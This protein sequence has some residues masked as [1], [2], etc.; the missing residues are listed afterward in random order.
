MLKRIFLCLLFFSFLIPHQPVSAQDS[1]EYPVYVVQDGDTLSLISMRFGLSVDDLKEVNGIT[2]P[3]KLSAGMELKIPSLQGVSGKLITITVPLGEDLQSLS[4]KYNTSKDLLIR[5]NRITSPQ[6]VYA[7]TNL[8]I[9]QGSDEIALQPFDSLKPQESWL[10]YS[11]KNKENYWSLMF[12]NKKNRSWDFLTSD[13]IYRSSTSEQKDSNVISSL[14]NGISI[15]PL[16]LVQGTT[17]KIRIKTTKPAEINA[18]L[19]E[20]TLH[21]YLDGENEYVALQGINAVQ[22]VGLIP[23]V[24]NIKSSQTNGSGFE[25]MV[26]VTAGNYASDPPLEVDPATLD[27]NTIAQEDN[28]IINVLQDS[29]PTRY[30]K[31]LFRYPT[32]EPCVK[33]W[34]GNRRVYNETY[35]SFHTGLDLGVCANNL[36][37]YAAAP[38]KVVFVGKLNVRGNA[39]VID[40]GWGIYTGYWHQEEMMV[41]VGDIVDTGQIIGIIGATG[42]VTGPH[43]HWEIRVNGVQVDP[44]QWVETPF[45]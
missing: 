37:I 16:P 7:G 6:E 21:F 24:F 13:V 3:N 33:S 45:P 18:S 14:V 2:D 31:E 19:G 15:D 43:L 4:L 10:E 12:K 22:E 32:D 41:K 1:P 36:N 11:I 5:L 25:Q 34:F 44:T 39:T 30:W 29:S 35:N 38:G 20:N 8:I 28:Q 42:R 27:P 40:H 9:P 17:T 23:F 26:L